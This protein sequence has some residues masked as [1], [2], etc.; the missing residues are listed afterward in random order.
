MVG[1]AGWRT[2]LDR[3]D[4]LVKRSVA[5]FGGR[6]VNTTGDGAVA[7]F[8][9][10]SRAVECAAAIVAGAP[11]HSGCVFVLECT[12]ARSNDGVT[13]SAGWPFSSRPEWERLPDPTR[14]S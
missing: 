8:D 10:P 5:R 2:V 13:T 14:P 4:A 1:D 11:P 6:I 12:R 9:G 3:H 7:I